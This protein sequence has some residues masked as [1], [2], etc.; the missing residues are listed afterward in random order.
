VNTSCGTLAEETEDYL[1]ETGHLRSKDQSISH[2]ILV[3]DMR[4]SVIL[5][6]EVPYKCPYNVLDGVDHRT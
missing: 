5:R 2:I 3:V 4:S 1:R 6:V